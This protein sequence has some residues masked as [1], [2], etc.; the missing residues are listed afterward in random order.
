M[1][2][3]L[4]MSNCLKAAMYDILDVVVPNRLT[5][6]Q[7]ENICVYKEVYEDKIKNEFRVTFTYHVTDELKDVEKCLKEKLTNPIANFELIIT[8]RLIKLTFKSINNK[9][10]GEFN[11]IKNNVSALNKLKIFNKRLNM[12]AQIYHKDIYNLLTHNE[13]CDDYMFYFLHQGGKTM[14]FA[15]L[16]IY[17]NSIPINVENLSTVNI[18]EDYPDLYIIHCSYLNALY[19]SLNR[20]IA[21]IENGWKNNWKTC[22]VDTPLTKLYLEELKELKE[23]KKE[24]KYN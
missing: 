24:L 3:T 11:A 8:N 16:L 14:G 4:Y 22:T 7:A 20:R 21:S 17:K 15:R 1:T 5:V 19:V 10:I 12:I 6:K 13:I 9:L 2:L 23:I 18:K